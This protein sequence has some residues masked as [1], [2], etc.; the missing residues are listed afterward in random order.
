MTLQCLPDL[1]VYWCFVA[2]AFHE[3]LTG[4]VNTVRLGNCLHAANI[5]Y[6]VG[7][8]VKE[9]LLYE[10]GGNAC[11]VGGMWYIW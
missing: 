5:G 2:K 10:R 6:S 11:G 1:L 7:I 9:V 3:T 8:V 4:F